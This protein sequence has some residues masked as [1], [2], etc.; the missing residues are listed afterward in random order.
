MNVSEAIKLIHDKKGANNIFRTGLLKDMRRIDTDTSRVFYNNQTYRDIWKFTENDRNIFRRFSVQYTGYVLSSYQKRNMNRAIQNCSMKDIEQ[1]IFMVAIGMYAHQDLFR[2]IA[3]SAYWD[4]GLKEFI[5]EAA[6]NPGCLK[7]KPFFDTHKSNYLDELMQL[8]FLLREV[9]PEA[10]NEVEAAWTVWYGKEVEHGFWDKY[11][12][13][14]WIGSFRTELEKGSIYKSFYED[15]K[16][17]CEQC[18]VEKV[19]KS[20]ASYAGGY[21]VT[22]DYY[23]THYYYGENI[24]TWLKGVANDM[25]F[26]TGKEPRY[27]EIISRNPE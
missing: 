15:V 6:K 8:I 16:N 25:G 19:K 22:G 10:A 21:P 9:S 4:L 14:D 13:Y 23:E 26:F 17:A 2:K 18:R 24:G 3:V 7:N 12:T 5:D 27:I 11:Y 1:E 20:Y